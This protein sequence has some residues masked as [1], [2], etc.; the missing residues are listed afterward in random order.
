M[1]LKEVACRTEVIADT[2]FRKEYDCMIRNV[3][4]D[5]G[6]VL[7]RFDRAY[8]I[9]RLGVDAAD[10]LLLM[11]E[12]FRSLEWARLDRG[13][14]TES[15]AI[16]NICNR[17]PGRLHGAVKELVTD[18]ERPIHP[19]EGMYELVRELKENGYGIYL[20]SNASV[21]QHEYWPD[22]PVSTFFDGKLISADVNLVKPQPE[23]YS[24]LCSTFSL[25]PRECFMIDDTPQNI[26]G[27]L[28]ADLSG[29]V[30]NDNVQDLRTAMKQMGVHI[31]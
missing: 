2:L 3:I 8:F 24:L 17:M 7:I 12:V 15:D 23:I 26:E 20:L 25:S 14:I 22:I 18:W 31:K 30:F 16:S 5:M 10:G 1:N 21:R 19:I 27:A 4:F 9:R 28:E 6:G 13:S 11:N 29:C